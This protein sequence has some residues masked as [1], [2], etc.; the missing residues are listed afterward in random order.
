MELRPQFDTFL[1]DIRPSERNKEEWKRGSNTLRA[2]LLADPTLAPITT[3]TFLQGSV[4]RSTAVWPTGGKRSDVDVVL[5]TTIDHNIVTPTA[6]M[7]MFESFLNQHYEGKW[8]HR[9]APSGSSCPTLI[10]TS[11]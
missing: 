1:R 10:S 6:A 9:T 4:R 3:T 8:V 7:K 11:W 5:V 2:R